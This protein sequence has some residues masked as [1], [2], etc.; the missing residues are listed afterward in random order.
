MSEVYELLQNLHPLIKPV[1]FVGQGV[2]KDKS[3][4]PQKKQLEVSLLLNCF[5]CIVCTYMA[6]YTDNSKL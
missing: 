3:G 5:K 1:M 6:V 2:G 4:L